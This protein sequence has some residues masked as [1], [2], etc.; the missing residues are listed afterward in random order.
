MNFMTLAVDFLPPKVLKVRRLHGTWLS[1][2]H[3]DEDVGASVNLDKP[4]TPEDSGGLVCTLPSCCLAF[5]HSLIL[6]LLHI[7][8]AFIDIHRSQV[9]LSRLSRRL[10][11]GEVQPIRWGGGMN[12]GREGTGTWECVTRGC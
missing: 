1:H 2:T 3:T 6:L 4:L 7:A 5:M 9:L 11:S 8:R 12:G 10:A